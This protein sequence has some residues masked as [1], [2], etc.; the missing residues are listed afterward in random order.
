MGQHFSNALV[1]DNLNLHLN[2]ED[3][4]RCKEEQVIDN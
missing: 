3:K 1:V 2:I 4:K